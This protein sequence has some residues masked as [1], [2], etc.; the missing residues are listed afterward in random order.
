MSL[1]VQK[2]GGSSVSDAEGIKRVAKR[3][4][5]TQ[6]A[7]NDVIVVVSAMGDSTDELLDLAGQITTG[8]ADPACTQS[9]HNL[10]GAGTQHSVTPQAK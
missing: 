10:C 9:R 3:V 6:K 1:V 4:V 8:F 7:G 5:D 2:F